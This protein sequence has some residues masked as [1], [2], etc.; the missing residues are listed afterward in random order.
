MRR[1][2]TGRGRCTAD[3]HAH[4]YHRHLRAKAGAPGPPTDQPARGPPP[5]RDVQG[6][7]QRQPP[8]AAARPGP[9]RG[10]VRHRPRRPGGYARPGGLQPARPPGRPA[11]PGGPPRRQPHLLSP[12]RPL[13]P[14]AA[15]TG[16]VPARARRHRDPGKA[17]AVASR[18]PARPGPPTQRDNQH[19][20]ASGSPRAAWTAPATWKAHSA[21]WR[22]SKPSRCSAPPGSSPSA[23]TAAAPGRGWWRTP[24]LLALAAA[25][26]LLLAG[27]AVDRLAHQH[28]LGTTLYLATVAVGGVF[29]FRTAIDVLRRRRL[30][31]GTLLV[32]ATAGA[33]AL[34]VVSE[35][36]MLVVVFSLGGVLEDYVSDRVS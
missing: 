34:G 14:P 33:L 21:T 13:R 10:A 25:E 15:G 6:A 28:T 12:R 4:D 16:L 30:T 18:P 1:C 22:G 3:G 35:A 8:T 24:R 11:H 19:T 31:I 36:A 27:L 17:G 29:P 26:L 9:R 7:G 20:A 32:I 23:M 2:N 5:S